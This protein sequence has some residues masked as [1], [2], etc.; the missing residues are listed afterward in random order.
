MPNEWPRPCA[1]C[2]SL[3][4]EDDD[5]VCE[6]GRWS[7]LRCL[8]IARSNEVAARFGFK[9]VFVEATSDISPAD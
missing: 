9:P 7:H 3:I 4:E 6:G 1:R 2:P 5:S 8:D